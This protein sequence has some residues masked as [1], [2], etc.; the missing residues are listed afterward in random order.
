MHL[1]HSFGFELL[2]LSVQQLFAHTNEGSV[3]RQHLVFHRVVDGLLFEILHF[4]IV[5]LILHCDS[6]FDRIL[7]TP[8]H[9]QVSHFVHKYVT[10]IVIVSIVSSLLLQLFVSWQT[11]FDIAFVWQFGDWVFVLES[12]LFV[13][14]HWSFESDE[15]I[16]NVIFENVRDGFGVWHNTF[17]VWVS[18]ETVQTHFADDGS[19]S[20]FQQLDDFLR[21]IL[22]IRNHNEFAFATLRTSF[23]QI[24]WCSISNSD[25]VHSAIFRI[26]FHHC[27]DSLCIRHSS[28]SEQKHMS[29]IPFLHFLLEQVL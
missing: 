28:I 16:H 3:L 5:H 23:D 15:E 7:Q 9:F 14:E 4:H 27:N 1:L 17:D 8:Q 21:R 12:E 2:I 22:R 13:C 6:F 29:R 26:L 24:D 18:I 25:A 10:V 11:H 20:G 19:Q